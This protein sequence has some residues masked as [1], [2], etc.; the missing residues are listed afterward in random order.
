MN[1]QTIKISL[2]YESNTNPRGKAFEGA[3]FDDLVA[4]VKEKGVLVPVIVR[5]RPKGDKQFEI[6]AGNRRFRAAKLAGL[7]EIAA[8]IEKLTD[9][10]AREV[11]IVENLHRE[12]IHPLDEGEAYRK[13]IEEGKNYDIVAVAA[14]VG[15]GIAYVRRRLILTDLTADAKKAYRSEKVNAGQVELIARLGSDDQARAIKMVTQRNYGTGDLREWIQKAV[16]EKL[17]VAPPWKGHEDLVAAMAPCPECSKKKGGNLFGEGA[18]E[19]CGDP[20]CFARRLAAHIQ[21]TIEKFKS[22]KKPLL[23]VSAGYRNS[24]DK[25]PKGMLSRGEYR[26]VLDHRECKSAVIALVADGDLDDDLG[27][28][29]SVCVDKACEIHGSHDTPY[30]QTPAERAKR[31]KELARMRAKEDRDYA[32]FVGK[33]RKAVRWPLSEKALGIL[34]EHAIDCHGLT[35]LLPVARRLGLKQVKEKVSYGRFNNSFKPPLR[36]WL[37]K[38]PKEDRLRMLFELVLEQAESKNL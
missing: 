36:D 11:Q 24:G 6:V 30:R 27:K 13:L 21:L 18:A 20:T 33:I 19:Q 4:S 34:I 10:E 25:I 26:E 2:A 38:A 15:K 3:A 14:K 37:K 35:S 17:S 8:R 29:I 16:V 5:P 1:L 28:V 23:L 9:E 7:E 22:D 31:K 12:D 32:A